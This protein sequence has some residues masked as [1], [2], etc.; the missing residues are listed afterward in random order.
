[1]LSLSSQS[2][3]LVTVVLAEVGKIRLAVEVGHKIT[4][5]R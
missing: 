4:I 2:I 5:I 1:M 3:I